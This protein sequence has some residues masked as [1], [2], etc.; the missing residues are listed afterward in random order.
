MYVGLRHDSCGL[1]TL[2]EIDFCYG[3]FESC[4]NPSWTLV[5]DPGLS[6]EG[7]GALVKAYQENYV[8]PP[9]LAIVGGLSYPTSLI[10]VCF[11]MQ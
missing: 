9:D 5:S 11:D 4:P 8:F 6:K 1:S 2:L 10:A 3:Q 7:L